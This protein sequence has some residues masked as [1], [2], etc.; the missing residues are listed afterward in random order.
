MSAADGVIWE[1]QHLIAGY[2]DE[3]MT[4]LVP[5]DVLKEGSLAGGLQL[6]QVLFAGGKLLSGIKIADR[7][8]NMQKDNYRLA[9]QEIV[10]QTVAKY[11]QVKLAQEVVKIQEEAL[12]IAGEHLEDVEKMHD[13][14]LVSEYDKL[15][16]ELEYRR[17]EP[18]LVKSRH[19]L[20]L[21]Q[22]DFCNHTGLE[23]GLPLELETAFELPEVEMMELSEAIETGL[24]ERIEVQL[25]ELNVRIQEVIV[26]MEKADFYPVVGLRASYSYYTSAGGYE[27]KGDDFGVQASIG[28]GFEYP[29]FSGLTRLSEVREAHWQVKKAEEKDADLQNLIKLDIRNAWQQ[30]EHSRQNLAVQKDNVELAERGWQIAQARYA[31]GQGTELEIADAQLMQKQAKLNYSRSIYELI[32]AKV[33]FE[34]ATGVNLE[35][36]KGAIK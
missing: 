31:A 16:A 33:Y 3:A 6:D 10:Y 9:V 34:K 11:Y 1:N 18:E 12:S 5:S 7:V 17:L 26:K 13:Q 4:E 23:S 32:L 36:Y 35:K 19:N 14:G 2:L 24:G 30:L 28:I 20:K 25:S 27:I 15:R 8:R 21:A 29:L 22:E